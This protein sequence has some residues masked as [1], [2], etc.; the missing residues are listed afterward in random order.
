[1]KRV[2]LM[3]L[4][5][6]LTFGVANAQLKLG[7]KLKKG[8][9]ALTEE[10]EKAS[11]N[12]QQSTPT[13]PQ[14]PAQTASVQ[15]AAAVSSTP[16]EGFDEF[17]AS[18]IPANAL[19]V[20]IDRGSAR[21]TGTKDS[22]LK[23]IQRAIDLA[24]NGGVVCVAEGNYLGNLDRGWIEIKGK[25]VSII[26]GFNA[27]FTDRDPQ[28]YVTRI[29]PTV[30]QRGTIGMGLLMLECISD[31]SA[32]MVIDG[33]SFDLGNYLEYCPADPTDPRWGCPEGCKTGRVKPISEPPNTAIRSIGGNFSGNLTIRNCMFLNSSF[34]GILLMHKGGNWEIYN[35]VFVSNIYASCEVNG[36]L[37]Q[38]TN[39]HKCTVDFHHNT[40]LFSW[41]ATKEM[42]DMSY[43]YRMRN[44][45]DHDVHHNIFGCSNLSAIDNGWDDSTLPADKRKITSAWDNLFFMNKGDITIPGTSGGQWL[46]VPAKRFDEVMSLVKYENN[47]E[48]PSTSNFKDL[49]DPAYLK[50][51]ANLKIMTT[52]SYDPNSAANLYRE[53]H[54]LNKQGTSTTRVSMYGNRYD[55]DQAL[56]FFGAEEGY[57]AQKIK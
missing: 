33:I 36:A 31:M 22:P 25:Y 41:C 35:N 14:K 57:G 8:L 17:S 56:V 46:F 40:V 51:F 24:P 2:V 38:T 37:N 11:S 39:A 43:G 6:F 49:I 44:G 13:P 42:E 30:Q 10:V 26:G 9:N 32:S 18:N 20:T 15:Q 21:G 34:Y 12:N 47:R 1:M 16:S 45:V 3:I 28:K 29:Q 7:D 48:L 27:D 19:Y 53:A 55:F 54:G 5:T 50:G 23:D 52:S 4:A